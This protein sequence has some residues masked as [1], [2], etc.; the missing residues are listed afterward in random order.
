VTGLGLLALLAVGA[1]AGAEHGTPGTTQLISRATGL[2]TVPSATTNNSFLGEDPSGNYNAAGRTISGDGNRIVFASDAD[3]LSPLD[4]NRFRNIFVRDR[5]TQTTFL[6]SRGNGPSGAAANND[7][8]EPT[9]S[10]DGLKVAFTTK[11]SNLGDGAPTNNNEKIYV[12]T[13]ST[14]AND[15][16]SQATGTSGPFATTF[17]GQPSLDEH[18]A[19]VAFATFS[20]LDATDGVF[21][22]DFDRDVYVRTLATDT[23][24]LV[25]RADG[26]AGAAGNGESRAPSISGDG[27]HVAFDSTSSNLIGAADTNTK[28]DVFVRDLGTGTTVLASRATTA[29]G[30]LGNG[31]SV[32]PS[33]SFNGSKVAFGS[34]ATNLDAD[35]TSGT[36]VFVRD[37]AGSTTVLASRKN[38]STGAQVNFSNQF[39][40]PALSSDGTTVAFTAGGA[41]VDPTIGDPPGFSTFVRV[42]ATGVTRLAS[43]AAAAVPPDGLSFSPSL[44]ADGTLVVFD[45]LARNLGTDADTAFR[46]VYL[47]DLANST[48]KSIVRPGMDS[49]PFANSGL[50]SSDS[51]PTGV[52][53]DGRYVVFSSRADWI[54]SADDNAF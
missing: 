30:A 27:T 37:L 7:S 5:S 48:T 3:G 36:N 42:L 47:R 26:V 14:G 2:T 38:G 52:S 9:I 20:A 49:V 24:T 39:Q 51:A 6:V 54:S 12:R 45:S 22:S 11:A 21:P 28:R 41:G 25:S 8:W 1:P 19:K 17:T 23:T 31:D 13:I 29:G 32:Y 15:F 40:A 35:A 50:D 34:V 16:A 4:D 10:Q 44:S 18:G 33:L 46:G 53:S 43:R